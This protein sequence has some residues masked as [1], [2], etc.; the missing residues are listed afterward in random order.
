MDC[1][2][3]E[4]PM[5]LLRELV[6]SQQRCIAVVARG[7]DAEWYDAHARRAAAFRAAQELLREYGLRFKYNL[8]AEEIPHERSASSG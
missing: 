7:M 3:D 5:Q 6:L 2:H 4:R 1:T 8:P